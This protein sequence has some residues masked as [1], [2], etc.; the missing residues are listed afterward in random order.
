M[1]HNFFINLD[2]YCELVDYQVLLKRLIIHLVLVSIYLCTHVVPWYESFKIQ[3]GDQD[4]WKFILQAN[5]FCCH[6]ERDYTNTQRVNLQ[7]WILSV[8]QTYETEWC[9]RFFKTL[10]QCFDSNVSF[11]ESFLFLESYLQ[12]SCWFIIILLI[13]SKCK[14]NTKSI[15]DKYSAL[16]EVEDEK[17]SQVAVKYG[18]PKKN[19]SA[20][21]KHKDK[22]FE[23]TKKGS[24]SKRKRLRQ[25]TLANLDQTMFKWLLVVRRKDVVVSVLVFKAKAIEFAEKKKIENF[26]ASDDCLDRWWVI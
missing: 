14:L 21:L 22:M 3:S 4:D 17:K 15:K 25:N 8:A 7:R 12:D 9:H 10:F 16:T 18:M 19:L 13:R 5:Y 2:T 6:L 11:D 20:W 23:A 26:K 24:N 1:P